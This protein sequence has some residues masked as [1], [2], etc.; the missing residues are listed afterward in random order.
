MQAAVCVH[1]PALWELL[2]TRQVG[3]VRTACQTVTSALM[4]NTASSVEAPSTYRMAYVLPIVPSVQIFSPPYLFFPP[5]FMYTQM[6]E[7]V[8]VVVVVGYSGYCGK[9]Q[10]VHNNVKTSST[11]HNVHM[12][13]RLGNWSVIYIHEIKAAFRK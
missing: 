10:L 9:H 5:S 1:H 8:S 3:T 11:P 4:P 7:N 12:V 13:N 6:H 2:G